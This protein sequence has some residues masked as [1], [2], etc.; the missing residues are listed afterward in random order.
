MTELV[1]RLD[2]G[3]VTGRH[4]WFA[5]F[6]SFAKTVQR[7][8]LDS[9][10]DSTMPSGRVVHSGVLPSR[11]WY[12]KAVGRLE[13]FACLDHNRLENDWPSPAPI[14]LSHARQLLDT[15]YSHDMPPANVSSSVR[16]GIAYT[17]LGSK[18]EIFIEFLN[19]GSAYG[20]VMDDEDIDGEPRTFPV[21]CNES[22]YDDLIEIISSAVHA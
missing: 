4:D 7:V 20:A 11:T 6:S 22:G 13:R 16:G 9:M 1:E 12:P 14:A 8:F 2:M 10:T 19:D 15:L 18:H 5:R 3:S 21:E 17:F